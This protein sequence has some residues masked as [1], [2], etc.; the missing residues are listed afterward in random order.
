MMIDTITVGATLDFSTEVVNYPPSEGWT[1]KFRLVPKTGNT[2]INLTSAESEGK[3]RVQ[4][5]PVTS[6]TWT[7]GEYSWTSWVEKLGAL[8]PTES[9]VVRLLPNPTTTIA[10]VDNR[11]FAAQLL[12]QIEASMAAMGNKARLKYSIGDRSAEYH[13]YTDL[14]AARSRLQ[15]EVA[16][17]NAAAALRAGLPSRNRILV[18]F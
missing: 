11:S 9:G 4:V 7:A 14:L 13:S 16:S 5:G 18:R 12:E 3:H 2:V 10:Y 6:A 17:E 1:L 15:R 8:Y